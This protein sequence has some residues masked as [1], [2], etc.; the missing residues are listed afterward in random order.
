MGELQTICSVVR[1]A[2]SKFS[3]FQSKPFVSFT[4]NCTL[5]V[6]SG[7]SWWTTSSEGSAQQVSFPM[8]D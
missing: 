1:F 6:Q 7:Q 5:E 2:W 4:S 8:A 3:C